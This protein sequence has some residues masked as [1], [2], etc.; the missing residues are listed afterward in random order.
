MA[1]F[2]N[3]EVTSSLVKKGFKLSKGHGNKHIYY[4]LYNEDD[5]KTG[6]NTHVSKNQQDINN[7]LISCMANDMK[8]S[9]EQFI[10]FV[11]CHISDKDYLDI[12]R[13]KGIKV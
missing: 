6:I 8:L 12:L 5:K 2:K 1:N 10:D 3:K 7:H 4:E 11:R 9:R 13:L